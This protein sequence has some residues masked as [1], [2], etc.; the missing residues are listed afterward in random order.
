MVR[1]LRET[2]QLQAAIAR[3]RFLALLEGDRARKVQADTLAD[4][5]TANADTVFGREHGFA[6]IRDIDDYR[7]AVPIRD[8]AQLQPWIDRAAQAEKAV[9][10]AADPVR[11]WKTTGTTSQA[12]R[13]PVTPASAS[14]TMESFLALSGTQ[15]HYH[16]ELGER[17]DA[18]LVAHLSPRPIKE[19]LGD[20]RFPF[21]S[22][23][24]VP[25]EVRPGNE[26]YLAPWLLPLQEVAEDD[27]ER[28]YF[29]LCFAALHD[30]RGIMCLH[31]SRFHTIVAVLDRS[32]P[33]LV[34][35]LADGT[36][37]GRPA[38]APRPEVASR[39]ES[40]ATATGSLRPRDVWPNLVAL[41]SW[42]G[43]YIARYRDVMESAFCGRFIAM[44]S[45]S[46]ECFAT[47]TVD[48]DLIGQPLN[49]RGAVFEFVPVDTAIDAG[50][51][52]LQFHELSVGAS[53]EI[54]LTT[55]AGMYRYAMCDLFKVTGFI[56]EVPRLEYVGRRSVSDLTGEK[57]A[58]EQVSDVVTAA[59]A[60]AGQR[61][62]D[63]TLC[64]LQE[65]DGV[66]RPGYVLVIELVGWSREKCDQLAA[67]I[68]DRFKA[69]NS[70]YELKRNFHDLDP[71]AI[72]PVPRGTFARQRAEL[73]RGGMPAGQLK[74]RILHASGAGMLAQLRELAGAG[75]P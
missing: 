28:L 10:T 24:E 19:Y 64:G 31:P 51:P 14:R 54:V 20:G 26:I 71:V 1:G 22:T 39:L 56:G 66:A 62:V 69:V 46:S 60:A 21:C 12:K 3:N 47:M 18:V 68:D 41:S 73:I 7:A 52:T 11:F 42:S 57:L 8:Y 55:L 40:I 16:P 2:L 29:L 48:Q 38:R 44:P 58:E 70:R 25:I 34:K 45:I 50:T 17:A 9:L 63:F 6:A 43:S 5:V 15:Q 27:A 53:Y 23:T 37:L 13:I 33:R 59:L 49:V 67:D 61:P 65:A 32:W 30:L 75:R 74:D 36:L 4:C 35:E 72:E